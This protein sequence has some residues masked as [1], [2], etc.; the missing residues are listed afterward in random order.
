[1]KVAHDGQI[2]NVGKVLISGGS[3]GNARIPWHLIVHLASSDADLPS[4]NETATIPLS[5]FKL[6]PEALDAV[7][8][9]W[10]NTPAGSTSENL[11]IC[12]GSV[13]TVG[14][15]VTVTLQHVTLVA[16]SSGV[17]SDT[18]DAIAALSQEELDAIETKDE[19]TLYVVK[20]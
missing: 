18:V 17:H 2:Y 9:F 12:T 16:G 13:D 14:E 5:D 11:Y 6:T 8:I 3:S 20:G 15:S 19:R 4:K 10:Y 1:M 7:Y